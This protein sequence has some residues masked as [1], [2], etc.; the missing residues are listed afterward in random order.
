[1]MNQ[2][3][4]PTRAEEAVSAPS[5]HTFTGNAAL[6]IEEPLIFETG[7]LEATGVDLPR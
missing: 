7:R 1:M 3:G 5:V 2:T 4:R 6:D